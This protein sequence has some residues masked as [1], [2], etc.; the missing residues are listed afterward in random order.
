VTTPYRRPES[1]LVVVYT[2]DLDVLVLERVSPAGFWQSVTGGLEW[3]EPAGTAAERELREE[4]GLPPE[5]LR[6]GDMEHRFP[7]LPA[8][9]HRYSPEVQSNL[10]HVWYLE[11]PSRRDVVLNP[12]EHATAEW[13]PLAEAIARVSSWTNKAALERLL[14]NR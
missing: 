5:G 11:L 2:R 3:G 14:P 12:A 10:E 1:V 7:I 6:D 4:T 9:R 8:W 13:L